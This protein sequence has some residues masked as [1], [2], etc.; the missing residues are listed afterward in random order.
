MTIFSWKTLRAETF[1]YHLTSDISAL[2]L[3]CIIQVGISHR[4]CMAQNGGK[5]YFF[6]FL[7]AS[8]ARL[9]NLPLNSLESHK[10][11]SQLMVSEIFGL[12]Y[13]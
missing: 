13:L 7:F 3:I 4:A 12:N 11:A 10:T 6:F 5:K 2:G 8:L 9:M 1:F